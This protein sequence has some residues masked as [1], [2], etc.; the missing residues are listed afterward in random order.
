MVEEIIV[1]LKQFCS[2]PVAHIWGLP[3][4]LLQEN[5]N[6]QLFKKTY[7]QNI[8]FLIHMRKTLIV[9]K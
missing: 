7:K 4:I 1:V 3:T 5:E 2:T 6:I 9:I 8:D